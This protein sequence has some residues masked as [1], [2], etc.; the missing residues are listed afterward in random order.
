MTNTD[1]PLRNAPWGELMSTAAKCRGAHGAVI[2]SCVRDV[3]K[4]FELEFPV[5]ATAVAPL[6]SSGRGRGSGMTS[7]SNLAVSTWRRATSSWAITTVSW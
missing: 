7:P 4:I 3:K 2:D 5:F 6:D 1:A